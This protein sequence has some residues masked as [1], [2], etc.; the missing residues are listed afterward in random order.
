MNRL[1]IQSI[2]HAG[3][4]SSNAE[5]ARN[6][7]H[8]HL[9]QRKVQAR[10]VHLQRRRSSAM[11]QFMSLSTQHTHI[12]KGGFPQVLVQQPC[13]GPRAQGVGDSFWRT[14]LLWPM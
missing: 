5:G 2:A 1:A 8:V 13:L 6:M 4:Y 12:M 14:S 11:F 7:L 9:A 3:S 10:G